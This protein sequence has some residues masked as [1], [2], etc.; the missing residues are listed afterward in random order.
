MAELVDRASA[1]EPTTREKIGWAYALRLVGFVHDFVPRTL[2]VQ[3]HAVHDFYADAESSRF[4]LGF[5]VGVVFGF[6]PHEAF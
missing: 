4:E 1:F 2:E 3:R 5:G 6:D